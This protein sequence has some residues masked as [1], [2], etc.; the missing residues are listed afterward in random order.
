M[1][2]FAQENL[3]KTRGARGRDP[4]EDRDAH[5]L[6]VPRRRRVRLAREPAHRTASAVSLCRGNAP[7]LRGRACKRVSFSAAVVQRSRKK[8]DGARAG[9]QSSTSGNV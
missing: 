2:D 3:K 7:A 6:E 4:V 8:R 1:Y 5:G 9:G